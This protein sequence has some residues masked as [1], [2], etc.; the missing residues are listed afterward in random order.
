M[1]TCW[2]A[3]WFVSLTQ[4][5]CDAVDQ[6]VPERADHERRT[7]RTGDQRRAATAAEQPADRDERAEADERHRGRARVH[8][9]VVGSA[10]P[11][12]TEAAPANATSH[13]IETWSSVRAGSRVR[14]ESRIVETIAI[15]MNGTI[16]TGCSEVD[17]LDEPVGEELRRVGRAAAPPRRGS[18]AS[19]RCRRPTSRGRRSC[20]NRPTSASVRRPAAR[21]RSENRLVRKWNPNT[22]I[23]TAPKITHVV[24]CVNAAA[25]PI[26]NSAVRAPHDVRASWTNGIISDEQEQHRDVVEVAHVRRGEEEGHRGEQ[27]GQHHERIATAPEQGRAEREAREDRDADHQER[28]ERVAVDADDLLQQRA[29]ERHGRRGSRRRTGRSGPTPRRRAPGRPRGSPAR[30]TCT[31]RGHASARTGSGR[32]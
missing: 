13:Q 27:R 28:A 23:S 5:F 4:R 16:T 17:P 22:A 14:R 29:R 24:G 30:A 11:V 9:P 10:A 21:P 8:E 20:R 26:R 19:P 15:A 25:M 12:K 3:H 18:P 1:R 32:R 6:D 2:F 31:R 7:E